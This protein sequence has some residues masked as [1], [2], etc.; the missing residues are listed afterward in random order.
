MALAQCFVMY[1]YGFRVE[2]EKNLEPAFGLRVWAWGLELGI[3][4]PPK[5]DGTWKRKDM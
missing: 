5:G 2:E 3:G 4:D 1:V